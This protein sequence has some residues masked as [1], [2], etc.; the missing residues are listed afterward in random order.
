MSAFLP[1]DGSYF[2]RSP[3]LWASRHAVLSAWGKAAVGA[4]PTLEVIFRVRQR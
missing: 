2:F 4:V 1:G 3:V